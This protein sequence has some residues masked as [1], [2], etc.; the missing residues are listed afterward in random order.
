MPQLKHHHAQA[1][2]VHL[3]AGMRGCEC[4]REVRI[5]EWRR[6]EETRSAAELRDTQ[7]G[8]RLQRA[9]LVNSLDHS[10]P[11]SSLTQGF[12]QRPW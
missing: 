2:Q 11:S 6:S 5:Q 3:Q 12:S 8:T 4:G 7:L 10:P 9:E 1:E